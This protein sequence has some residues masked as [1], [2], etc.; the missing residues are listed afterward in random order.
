MCVCVS[1]PQHRVNTYT[2][3]GW[4]EDRGAVLSMAGL[5]VYVWL[6]TPDITFDSD[7][8][9]REGRERG[10]ERG[11]KKNKRESGRV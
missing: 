1:Y 11:R 8:G 4:A 5:S 10:R 7:Q 2:L 9:K 3:Q 6:S